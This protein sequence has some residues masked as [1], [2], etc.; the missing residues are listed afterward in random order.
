[1]EAEAEQHN[2]REKTMQNGTSVEQ[3][4]AT[5]ERTV[6]ELRQR[7]GFVPASENWI[8][9]ITGSISTENEDAFLKA[10]ELGREYRHADRPPDDPDD[11]P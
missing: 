4:L 6:D 11:Q 9:K 10:M 2:H 7:A 3:R 8:E 1:M 5:L